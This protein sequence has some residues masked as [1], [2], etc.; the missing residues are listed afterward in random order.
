MVVCQVVGDEAMLG[1][2]SEHLKQ[3][4]RLGETIKVYRYSETMVL[5]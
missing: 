3:T 5:E 1:G 2:A 4:L